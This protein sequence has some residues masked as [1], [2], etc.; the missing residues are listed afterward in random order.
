MTVKSYREFDE[1]FTLKMFNF[2]DFS[3]YYEKI[4]SARFLENVRVPLLLLHSHDDP[5]CTRKAIDYDE[6]NSKA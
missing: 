3:D 6:C 4:S 1:E 2:K 5:I